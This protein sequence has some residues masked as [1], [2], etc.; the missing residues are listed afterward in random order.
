M[1]S[2]QNFQMEKVQRTI[3]EAEESASPLKHKKN[4]FHGHGMIGWS[5]PG[6]GLQ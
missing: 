1:L 2:R 4:H 3:E 6:L 5:S